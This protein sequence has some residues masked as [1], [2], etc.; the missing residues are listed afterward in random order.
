MLVL[1]NSQSSSWFGDLQLKQKGSH[2]FVCGT[3]VSLVKHYVPILTYKWMFRFSFKPYLRKTRLTYTSFLQIMNQNQGVGTILTF[4]YSW[5]CSLQPPTFAHAKRTHPTRY[6]IYNII[7]IY[8]SHQRI[9]ENTAYTQQNL[10]LR[11]SG[12][13]GFYPLVNVGITI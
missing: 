6:N 9:N 12:F 1:S 4:S 7:Y 5:T 13:L 8:N 3:N 11:S 2:S 10:T